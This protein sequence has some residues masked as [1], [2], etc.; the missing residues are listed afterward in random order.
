MTNTPLQNL[1]RRRAR[2]RSRVSGT[3]QRP[4]LSVKISQ[5]HVTAQIIDDT[6][7]R[8]LV[9]ASTIGAKD[10]KGTMTERAAWV[11]THIATAATAHKI[12]QVVFDRNGK[13]YHG[14]VHA[15][16]SAA[17]AAGLEF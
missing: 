6:S 3:P 16:A 9:A 14:R 7:G 4:R 5:I 13:L 15:L 10:A 11:G 17:R 1:N 2:I 8:T 12:K